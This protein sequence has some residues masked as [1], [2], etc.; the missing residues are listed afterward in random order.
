MQ[1]RH[2]A[3]SLE[4]A[5][6]EAPALARL[7]ALAHESKERLQSLQTLIPMP[8]RSQVQAGPIEGETWCLLV[9]SNAA[10]NKFRQLLPVFVAHLRG[11]GWEVSAIRLKI[12]P[13]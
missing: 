1:R 9:R 3:I 8:L 10:A 5:S 4:Q 13:D 11:K 2:Y 12:Q 6:Q 7:A